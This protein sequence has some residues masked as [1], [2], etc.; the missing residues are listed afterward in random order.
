MPSIQQINQQQSSKFLTKKHL[1]VL[2]TSFKIVVG[3]II[4]W[5]AYNHYTAAKIITIPNDAYTL[6]NESH[7]K[8]LFASPY[9]KIIWFG[10]DCPISQQKKKIIDII[11]KEKQLDKYYIHHPFLQNSLRIDPNDKIGHF[12][13]QNCSGFVCIIVPS[14]RTIIQTSEEHLMRDMIE[15]QD[16]ISFK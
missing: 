5:L 14:A 15:Y 13:M 10:A 3:I 4:A 6:R 9:K 7:F 8:D 12:I 2:K 1:S 11:I 16:R